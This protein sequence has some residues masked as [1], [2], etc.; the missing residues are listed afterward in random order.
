MKIH[1]TLSKQLTN[2]LIKFCILK[3]EKTKG[4]K[5]I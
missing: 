5:Q 1:S 2:A 3:R 4:D